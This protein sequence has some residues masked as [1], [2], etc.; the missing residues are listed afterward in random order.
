MTSASCPA[1]AHICHD[2]HFTC[3]H[4]HSTVVFTTSGALEEE[5]M[6]TFQ[7]LSPRNFVYKNDENRHLNN[8][9]RH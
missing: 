6:N 9:S 8:D 4:I 1:V 2:T 7:I 3:V 5:K